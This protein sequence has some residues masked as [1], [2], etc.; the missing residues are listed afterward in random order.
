M[1]S[2]KLIN[3]ERVFFLIA[4]TMSLY[5]TMSLISTSATNAGQPTKT[6]AD[7]P[8]GKPEASI[9]LASAA[10]VD[11][12]KGE[13]RYSDTKIVEVDFRGPGVDKQPSG[14]ATRTYD[15]TPHAGG[16]DFNDSKWEVI[17][18]TT[19]DQ[20]RGNGRLAFNWYR[21]KLTGP[22]RIGDFDPTGTTAVFD[23]SFDDYAQI[24]V[25]GELSRALGQSCSSVTAGW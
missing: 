25:D 9:D 5:A 19:L 24:W 7:V 1:R 2:H 15:Y 20:R 3:L 6:S 10:G 12:V 18:P 8:S 17:S 22:E 4:L 21:I 16:A 14:P 11:L 13:W 23:T